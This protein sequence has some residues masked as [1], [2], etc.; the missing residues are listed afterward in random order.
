MRTVRAF[1]QEPKEIATYEERTD[2]VLLLSKKE[3][4]AKGIFWATVS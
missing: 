2:H 4:I 3:A 1:G